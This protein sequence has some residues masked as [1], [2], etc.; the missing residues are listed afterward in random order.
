MAKFSFSSSRDCYKPSRFLVV[1]IHYNRKRVFEYCLNKTLLSLSEVD[2]LWVIDNGSNKSES[3]D[4]LMEET[5]RLCPFLNI[6]FSSISVNRGGNYAY[7]YVLNH[8]YKGIFQNVSHYIILGDDDYLLPA[9]NKCLPTT[10][11]INTL[12]CWNFNFHNFKT[13]DIYQAC[14]F[15]GCQSQYLASECLAD[16]IGENSE[17]SNLFVRILRKVFFSWYSDNRD[18]TYSS[19]SFL[20]APKH[21]SATLIPVRAMIS[22][23][24]QYKSIVSYPYGDVGIILILSCLN[25]VIFYDMACTNIGR[26][27]NYG[28][29]GNIARMAANHQGSFLCRGLPSLPKYTAISKLFVIKK[30]G[31]IVSHSNVLSNYILQHFV[32]LFSSR[33]AALRQHVSNAKSV[34]SII[35]VFSGL[36]LDILFLALLFLPIGQRLSNRLC[37]LYIDDKS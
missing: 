27:Y 22:A 18:D 34:T 12:Y 17:R 4:L 6:H 29:T 7:E 31:L 23:I 9:L 16:S 1:Y 37:S 11:D 10:L 32:F 21:S 20:Q 35:S 24:N 33:G 13:D 3:I 28:V 19:L 14:K 5:I 26:G 2:A 15:S 30:L 36:A 25:R 8:L